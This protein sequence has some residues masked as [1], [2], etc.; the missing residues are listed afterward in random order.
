[1]RRVLVICLAG[2]LAACGGGDDDDGGGGPPA[3]TVNVTGGNTFTGTNAIGYSTTTP[4]SCTVEGSPVPVATAILAVFVTDTGGDA[5]A[6]VS[7]NQERKGM[8]GISIFSARGNPF[9]TPTPIGAGRYDITSSS[10]FPDPDGLGNVTI[11]AASTAKNQPGTCGAQ[12]LEAETGT[13][14]ISSVNGGVISGSIDA[15]LKASDGGGKITG[16]FTTAACALA[17]PSC[18]SIV[19]DSPNTCV[20]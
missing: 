1:M 13:I 3:A 6:L 11:A 8:G 17:S 4:L 16:T 2:A 18:D 15:N 12:S 19:D 5:C 14:T 9:A 10:N 20:D 7:A